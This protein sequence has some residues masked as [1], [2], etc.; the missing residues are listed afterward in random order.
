MPAINWWWKLLAAAASEWQRPMLKTQILTKRLS[1]RMASADV[2]F[3]V[4][5]ARLLGFASSRRAKMSRWIALKLV[6]CAMLAGV[7]WQGASAADVDACS[8]FK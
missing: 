4:R 6:T 3:R 8:R 7:M 2:A 5:T 1:D